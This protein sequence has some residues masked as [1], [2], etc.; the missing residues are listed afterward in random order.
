MLSSDLRNRVIECD[1]IVF[2]RFKS[3]FCGIRFSPFSSWGLLRFFLGVCEIFS[4]WFFD[5]GFLLFSLRIWLKDLLELGLGLFLKRSEVPIGDRND[6]MLW[7]FV[8]NGVKVLIVEFSTVI[9][10]IGDIFLFLWNW[11]LSFTV[12]LPLLAESDMGATH[13]DQILIKTKQ[14]YLDDG[15]RVFETLF[16]LDP[17][18]TRYIVILVACDAS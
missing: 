2:L 1:T 16:S 6:V 9:P 15:Q 3:L 12:S 17:D 7:F 4:L 10:F 11:L 13:I 5:W 8:F 18:K 14:I